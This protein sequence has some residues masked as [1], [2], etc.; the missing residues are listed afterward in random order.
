MFDKIN[1]L[2]V[3]IGMLLAIFVLPFITQLLGKVKGGST[4]Q[5]ATVA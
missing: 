1:W 3:G 4:A 5:K 2:S